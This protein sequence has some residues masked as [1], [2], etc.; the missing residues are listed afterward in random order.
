VRA[1]SKVVSFRRELIEVA[2]TAAEVAQYM[3]GTP[4]RSA[5][6]R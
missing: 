5:L 6:C 2:F 4:S 1:G 3:Y